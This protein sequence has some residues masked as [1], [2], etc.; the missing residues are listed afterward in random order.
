MRGQAG[1]GGEDALLRGARTRSTHG[2][3]SAAGEAGVRTA[4]T[5]M[6]TYLGYYNVYATA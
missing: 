3:P 2:Q 1:P 6:Y 4:A 5:G